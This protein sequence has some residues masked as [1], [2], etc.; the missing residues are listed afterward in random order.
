MNEADWEQRVSD[1]WA[2]M[3]QRSEVEFLALIGN[4]A[5]KLPPDTGAGIF[6]RGSSLD[7]TGH[8]DL[9]V[10]LYRQALERGLTGERRR[11]AVIQLASSLR[12]LGRPEESVALITTE[13]DAGFPHLSPP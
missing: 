3:D 7:S 13:L 12:N 11:R 9:A 8:S 6:E 5:A 4:L 2:S 10:P 1:A